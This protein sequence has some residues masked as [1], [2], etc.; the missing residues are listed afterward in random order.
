[1]TNPDVALSP[2]ATPV[3]NH[4]GGVTLPT[5]SRYTRARHECQSGQ[6]RD[7][8]W[9]QGFHDC[10]HGTGLPSGDTAGPI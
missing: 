10:D 5:L 6:G 3:A 2:A 1:M 8:Q 7:E 9:S 4:H